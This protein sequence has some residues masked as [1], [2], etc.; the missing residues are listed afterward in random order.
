MKSTSPAEMETMDMAETESSTA[1]CNTA[2]CSRMSRRFGVLGLAA[3]A[4]LALSACGGGSENASDDGH[5]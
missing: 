1:L 5:R 2:P 3:A 4:V